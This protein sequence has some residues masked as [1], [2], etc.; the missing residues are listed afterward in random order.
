MRLKLDENITVAAQD[1]LVA[2]GHDVETVFDEDL[3]GRPDPDVLA[4]AITDERAEGLSSAPTRP[5]HRTA[6]PD[7]GCQ[8]YLCTIIDIL[9][10]KAVGWAI[11][12]TETEA[13]ARRLIGEADRPQLVIHAD[14]G[15]PDGR[16]DRRR[17]A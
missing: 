9:S 13:H 6:G 16:R 14:R 1:P 3:T 11:H 17:A 2:L 15:I 12:G 7:Q 10:R 5:L 8:V 4:A